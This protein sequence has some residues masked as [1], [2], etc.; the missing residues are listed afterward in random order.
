M[1]FNPIKMRIEALRQGR[2]EA[3]AQVSIFVFLELTIKNI[4]IRSEFS[5]ES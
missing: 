4:T 3:P 1:S 2:F 5:Y